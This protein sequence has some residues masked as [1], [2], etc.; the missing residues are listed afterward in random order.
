MSGSG[1]PNNEAAFRPDPRR[2]LRNPIHLMGIGFGSGLLRPAP[3]TWGSVA[4]WVV[5][6]VALRDLPAWSL[7]LLIILGT[8]AGI[9]VCGRTAADWQV[10]DHDAIVWDEWIGQWIALSGLAAWPLLWLPAF[11]LFRLFDIWKPGPIGWADRNCTGGL[12]IMADD[13]LAGAAACLATHMIG[14]ALDAG[15]VFVVASGSS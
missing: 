8:L 4:A 5:Y 7:V 9:Y 14:W 1:T 12:G 11:L 15:G 6:L 13:L 3:G 10:H 2:T